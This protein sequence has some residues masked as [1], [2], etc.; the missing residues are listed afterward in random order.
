MA[1]L[2]YRIDLKH[3]DVSAIQS[4]ADIKR[5]AKKLLPGALIEIGEDAGAKSWDAMANEMRKLKGF[6]A[7]PASE[8]TKHIRESGQK[9]KRTISAK[10][11]LTIE[12]E[13]AQEIRKR[14]K[15]K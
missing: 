8:R 6:K 4:D 9:F 3:L 10:D 5:T 11:K 1:K 13:I 2:N 12:T 14:I 7:S 15:R